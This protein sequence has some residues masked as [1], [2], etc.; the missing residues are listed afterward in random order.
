MERARKSDRER[1]RERE[2]DPEVQT[3]R[4]TA[5]ERVLEIDTEGILPEQL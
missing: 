3:K 4:D 1:E 5:P 2:R